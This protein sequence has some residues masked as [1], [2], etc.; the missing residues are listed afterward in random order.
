[1]SAS[2]CNEESI[3]FL[4]EQELPS[5][6]VPASA[7]KVWVAARG[8]D[9]PMPHCWTRTFVAVSLPAAMSAAAAVA[10]AAAAAAVC[11]D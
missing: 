3:T 5:G 2:G 10:A 1:M 9:V 11:R 4:Y 7:L 8:D 6:G